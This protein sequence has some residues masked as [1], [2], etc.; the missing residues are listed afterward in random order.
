MCLE[1]IYE[2]QRHKSA[3]NIMYLSSLI[4]TFVRYREFHNKV[5]PE[6]VSLLCRKFCVIN[7]PFTENIV[8]FCLED[9][10]LP[11][12]IIY[13][14]HIYVRFPSLANIASKRSQFFVLYCNIE[15][16]Q[17]FIGKKLQKYR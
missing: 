6:K 12:K 8:Y 3:C 11:E 17:I 15:K 10:C 5:P 14:K 9:I 7:K 4:S 2:Q 1:L 13:D 16:M